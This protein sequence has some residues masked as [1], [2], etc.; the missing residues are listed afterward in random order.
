MFAVVKV[1]GSQYRVSV[2]DTIKTQ[3]LTGDVGG[4]IRFNDVLMLSD[5][6]IT[7]GKPVVKGAFVKAT[8]A[9]QDREKT[10]LVVRY[11]RRGGMR[12]RHGQREHYTQLRI[13]E[14]G[15]E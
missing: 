6:E 10:L 7:V 8:I 3:R 15:K 4:E 9:K 12:R 13:T 2:G 11:R 5:A 14:I 1:G